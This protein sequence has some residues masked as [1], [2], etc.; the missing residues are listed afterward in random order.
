MHQAA[1]LLDVHSGAV[2]AGVDWGIA[3]GRFARSG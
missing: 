1:L 2:A 3:S